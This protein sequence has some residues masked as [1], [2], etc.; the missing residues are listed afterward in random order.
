M[1]T[2]IKKG[3]GHLSL[4]KR[5]N[6]GVKGDPKEKISQVT[7]LLIKK[8]HYQFKQCNKLKTK[9]IGMCMKYT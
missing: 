2:L 8:E 9:I 6:I 1:Y 3:G 4:I 5:G 7:I